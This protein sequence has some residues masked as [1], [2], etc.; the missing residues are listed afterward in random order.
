[1]LAVI[2]VVAA[3]FLLAVSQV[4]GTVQIEERLGGIA[5]GHSPSLLAVDSDEGIGEKA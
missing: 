5:S 3:A 2:A 1:V 4:V